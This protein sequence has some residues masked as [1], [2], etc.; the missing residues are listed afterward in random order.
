MNLY[1]QEDRFFDLYPSVFYQGFHNLLLQYTNN[2]GLPW[3]CFQRV[4]LFLSDV[5]DGVYIEL[6]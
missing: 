1:I 2:I 6:I 4:I 3:P 5:I